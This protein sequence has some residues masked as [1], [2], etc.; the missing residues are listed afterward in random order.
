MESPRRKP[1]IGIAGGIGSGKSTVA[2]EF[3]ELGCAVI[4]ADKIA[5]ELLDE[6]DVYGQIVASFGRQ[7][8]NRENKIDSSKLAEVVFSDPDNVSRLNSIIHPPVLVRIERL[9]RQLN[10]RD[11]V[12]AIVLDIPLLFEAGWEK[13]CDRLIFIDC[14]EALRAERVKK[15]GL[16]DEN[17]LKSRENFQISLDKKAELCDNTIDNNSGFEALA[18]QVTEI[19]TNI[20][21]DG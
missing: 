4:D 6:P 13:R 1:I 10:H 20:V 17:Q 3:A 8:L 11:A 15:M 9:I 21:N 7:I 5:H 16:F 2:A 19:F 18:A 14:N 12:K